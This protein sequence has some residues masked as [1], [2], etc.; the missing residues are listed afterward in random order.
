MNKLHAALPIIVKKYVWDMKYG[1]LGYP[2]FGAPDDA[3]HYLSARLP[4]TGSLLELGCGRGSLIRGLRQIGWMGSYCGVDIS[5]E[6]IGDARKS[7][8]QR[9]SWIV[10]DFESFRSPFKWD[11]VVMIE[12]MYYVRLGGL[13]AVLDQAMGM[14]AESGMFFARVHDINRHSEHVKT[15]HQ[16]YPST[17]RVGNNIFCIVAS[18]STHHSISRKGQG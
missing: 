4:E 16:L 9:S 7:A 15:M 3:L 6:A 13:P 17:E 11:A 10:S 5:K 1:V 8:D 12:S 18:S 2:Q 14:L